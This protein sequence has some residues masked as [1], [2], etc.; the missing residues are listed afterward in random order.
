MKGEMGEIGEM[1]GWRRM[2]CVADGIAL[3]GV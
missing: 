1:G 2:N 3:G